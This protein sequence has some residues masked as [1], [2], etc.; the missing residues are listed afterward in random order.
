MAAPALQLAAPRHRLLGGLTWAAVPLLSLVFWPELESA[1]L[2]PKAALLAVLA[3]LTWAVALATGAL[4]LPARW[5]AFAGAAFAYAAAC[6]LAWAFST[7]R[8]MGAHALLFILSGPLFAW[9]AIAGSARRQRR[10]V[11][12]IAFAGSVQAVLGLAQWWLGLDPFSWFGLAALGEHRMRVFGTLGNPEFVANFLAAALP[13]VL[14]L[15]TEARGW[16]RAVWITMALF[17]GL[18]IVGSG[19]RVSG[20]AAVLASVAFFGARRERLPALRRVAVVGLLI[21]VLVAAGVLAIGVRNQRGFSVS[22]S[23]RFVMW[24]ATL[25]QGAIRSPWAPAPAPLSTAT[26]RSSPPMCASGAMPRW[27]ATSAT[28]APPRATSCRP[29]TKPAGRAC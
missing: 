6:G 8:D 14:L 26:F 9:A 4:R 29:S 23:G 25:S 24:R 5:R 13:A 16:L 7:R 17:H 12:A 3:A 11:E 20:V 22:A 10:S 19:C 1:F 27:S 28:S 15:A 21:V 18:A 2:V